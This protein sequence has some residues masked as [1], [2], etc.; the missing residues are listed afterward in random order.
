MTID[1][2]QIAGVLLAGGQ[3]RR[4]G[5]G[6]KCLRDLGG[7][8]LLAH[9]VDRV[10]PQVGQLVLNA[11]G[12]PARFASLGLPVIEDVVGGFAGP[13]AGI[14]TGLE[15][16]QA[17]GLDWI[18]S[19]PTDAPFLPGDLVAT[20][21]GALGDEGAEIACAMSAGRT[22]PVVGL[23]PVHL[24]G[25]LRDA[26]VGEDIRKI[27]VWTARHR[28]AVAGFGVDPV[29]PFFNAN[30]AEDF[31]TAAALYAQLSG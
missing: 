28:L 31:E 13:L 7:R 11:N 30:R 17:Q 8:S 29:D 1:R 25:D 9:I 24:A 27:D 15:W 5:G 6:D 18:V 21:I 23:W 2:K 4:L 19:V 26:L 14:L 22:H 20:L 3:A 16:A 10:G 12:D